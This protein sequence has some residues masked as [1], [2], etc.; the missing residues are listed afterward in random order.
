[1]HAIKIDNYEREHGPGTFV[2]FRHLADV[3][4]ASIAE[5]LRKRLDIP[6]DATPTDM[7]REIDRRSVFIP[8]VDA[9][10]ERFDLSRLMDRL[11]LD[12]PE[13]VYL[14]WYHFDDVDE[15]ST[16]DLSLHFSDIWYP[17]ADDLEVI[18][19]R[20]QWV[21]SI[22]HAGMITVLDFNA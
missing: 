1:M 13:V 21:M 2:R 18:D 17:S 7:L 8:D 19:P 5:G 6:A 12:M 4:A 16:R 20:T 10:D 9:T 15:M 3:E 11:N 14:N 22:H